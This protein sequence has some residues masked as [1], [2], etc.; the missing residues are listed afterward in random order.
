[1]LPKVP[2]T[3]LP[4]NQGAPHPYFLGQNYLLWGIWLDPQILLVLIALRY[5]LK[6]CHFLLEELFL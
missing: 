4:G 2:A 6:Q 5:N 1:M 3:G